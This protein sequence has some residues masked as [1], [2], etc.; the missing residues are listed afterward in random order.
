[1][2]D[3]GKNKYQELKICGGDVLVLT[4]SFIIKILTTNGTP[5]KIIRAGVEISNVIPIYISTN[6]YVLVAEQGGKTCLLNCYKSGKHNYLQACP[7]GLEKIEETTYIGK[8]IMLRTQSNKIYVFALT[9]DAPVRM[10]E[11]Y[12]GLSPALLKVL[13]RKLTQA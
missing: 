3:G 6:M 11:V 2:L 5:K 4:R 13:H 7:E 10:F 12:D 1:M 8:W 9:K